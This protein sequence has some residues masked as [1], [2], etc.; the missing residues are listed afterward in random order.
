MYVEKRKFGKSILNQHVLS[1]NLQVFS[2]FKRR[3][4]IFR[5]VIYSQKSGAE[6]AEIIHVPVTSHLH[7]VPRVSEFPTRV[8]HL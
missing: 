1:K 8:A 6:G 4:C 3:D 5:A 7:S 2:L